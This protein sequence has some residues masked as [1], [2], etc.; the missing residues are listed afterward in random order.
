M[1]QAAAQAVVEANRIKRA[2]DLPPF[3][4]VP[5]KDVIGARQLLDRM[6]YAA[7]V[8]NWADDQAKCD[9]F[10]LLLRDRALVWWEQLIYE[11]V[12]VAVW[13]N[14]KR[15]FLKTYE[16]RYTAK[17]TCANFSDLVQRANES[18]N[19]YYLR[20][21]EAMARICE[22]KPADMGTVRTAVLPVAAGPPAVAAADRETIKAEGILDAEKFF[23]HQLFLAGLT[24]TL[25]SK[26]MEANKATLRESVAL[27]IE[28][29]TIHSD[30]RP[31]AVAVAAIAD[32][33][34]DEGEAAPEGLTDEEFAAINA[35]R[36]RD[37]KPP[38]RRFGRGSNGTTPKFSGNCRY[39]KKPGHMQKQCRARITAR[40]PMVDKDGKPFRRNVSAVTEDP[41]AVTSVPAASGDRA[42]NDSAMNSVGSI[43]ASALNT[44]N[45]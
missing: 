34:E 18:V 19:D 1:A 28:L 3:F 25:R 14:V 15:E 20:I 24:P 17:T 11:G 8:A 9:N 4:G 16:P 43:M 44:L 2:T 39:C 32:G 21:C 12:D 38:F 26:V 42:N 29:E 30:R 40:A 36:R 5:S 10:Y 35:I 23:R 22:Q 37:G 45:W 6:T 41:T 7:R 13:D 27:A 33:E 31:R